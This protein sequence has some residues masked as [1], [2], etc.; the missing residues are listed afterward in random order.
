MGLNSRR[1]QAEPTG[2]SGRNRETRREPGTDPDRRDPRFRSRWWRWRR[3]TEDELD[4]LVHQF[5][6]YRRRLRWW[7]R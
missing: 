5:A 2:N 1:P 4:D 3:Q 6:G 7:V